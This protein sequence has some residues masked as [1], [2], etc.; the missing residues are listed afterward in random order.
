MLSEVNYQKLTHKENNLY[1][2]T[3]QWRTN[4]EGD[5]ALTDTELKNIRSTSQ[6]REFSWDK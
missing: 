4:L 2:A 6:E 3:Q 5:S 1:Q